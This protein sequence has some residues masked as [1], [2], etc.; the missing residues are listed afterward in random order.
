MDTDTTNSVKPE[1]K[2]KQISRYASLIKD[3]LASLKDMGIIVFVILII[4]FRDS[5]VDFVKNHDIK[6]GNINAF[7][8][9]IAI[10]SLQQDKQLVNAQ[11]T[12]ADLKTQNS[13]LENTLNEAKAQISDVVL[14]GKI[15]TLEKI[16]AQVIPAASKV[17]DSLQTTIAANSALVQQLQTATNITPTWAVVFGGDS[18][19][20][21]ARYEIETAARKLGITNA[22]IYYRQGSYRSVVI[23]SDRSQAN[24][25]LA[26]LKQSKGDAYIVNMSTWCPQTK[27][28]AGY[29]ECGTLKKNQPQ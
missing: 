2:F 13:N 20:D 9:D 6:L 19:L 27:E 29:Y 24:Q 17:Q 7:G 26:K 5:V 8:I 10:E 14:R 15:A 18:T 28:G 1:S 16:N 23:T 22:A 11:A 12:I 25:F 4:F 21:A 3:I